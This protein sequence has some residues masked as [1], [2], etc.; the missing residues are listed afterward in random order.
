MKEGFRSFGPTL[1][2]LVAFAWPT[3][4]LLAPLQIRP[5]LVVARFR[6]ELVALL[7]ALAAVVSSF[8]NYFIY[9]A[10]ARLHWLTRGR[11]A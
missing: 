6:P 1:L 10:A 8:V 5:A 7:L 9:S 3:L 4:I 2:L 11:D